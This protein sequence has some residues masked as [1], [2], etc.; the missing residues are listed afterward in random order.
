[1]K[2]NFDKGTPTDTGSNAGG[3]TSHANADDNL[4]DEDDDD[5]NDDDDDGGDD[6]GDG[7]FATTKLASK[8]LS[9]LPG[10]VLSSP[11]DGGIPTAPDT[12]SP[13]RS[14]TVGTRGRAHASK[15]KDP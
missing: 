8:S 4:N 1:M 9:L 11:L 6:G 7:K 3:F 13:R 14:A 5:D 10:L 15:R 2:L 12:T